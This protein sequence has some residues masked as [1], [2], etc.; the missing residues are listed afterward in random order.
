MIEK[1]HGNQSAHNVAILQYV[2]NQAQASYAELFKKFRDG[3]DNEVTCNKRFSKKME[4]LTSTEQLQATGRGHDRVFT[5]GPA[6]GKPRP[7]A[8]WMERVHKP[9]HR[10]EKPAAT[11]QEP[12]LQPWVTACAGKPAPPPT[13]NAMQAPVY[14]PPRSSAALR[15]G[16]LDYQSKPSRGDRC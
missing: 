15:P 6:A 5:I 14:V 16:A 12:D 1:T 2:A 10:H 11:A 9:R 7:S 4:Y 13:Y 3:G 8:K